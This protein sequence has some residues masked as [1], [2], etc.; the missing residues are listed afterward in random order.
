[1]YIAFPHPD[2]KCNFYSFEKIEE[3]N[4][5]NFPMSIIHVSK[6][7]LFHFPDEGDEDLERKAPTLYVAMNQ[8]LG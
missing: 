2:A 1:M 4:K 3:Y 6:R 8:P 5:H 7:N